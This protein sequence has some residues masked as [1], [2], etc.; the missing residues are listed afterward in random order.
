VITN[1]HLVILVPMRRRVSLLYEE[2]AAICDRA[3]TRLSKLLSI[4]SADIFGQYHTTR[5]F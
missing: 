5:P 4:D 3:P 2:A 1:F